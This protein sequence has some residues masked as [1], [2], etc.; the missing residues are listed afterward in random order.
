MTNG[1]QSYAVFTYECGDLDF[2]NLAVIGY[3]A[4]LGPHKTHPLSDT[5][6]TAD[7]IACV[8]LKSVWNN[9]VYDLTPGDGTIY[10]T[11]PEPSDFIGMLPLI[12]ATTS[13]MWS[14]LIFRKLC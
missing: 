10:A 4:P 2:P 9:I 5:D 13:S 11:T 14:S 3:Y 1:T 7:T 12:L 6:V 8:H